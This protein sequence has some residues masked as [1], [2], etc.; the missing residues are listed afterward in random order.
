MSP[1]LLELTQLIVNMGAET[2][3]FQIFDVKDYF[4]NFL[5]D[6]FEDKWHE[7]IIFNIALPS[8]DLEKAY[9]KYSA[10][11]RVNSVPM[12][13]KEISIA[14]Q[15][16]QKIASEAKEFFRFCQ[17]KLRFPFDIINEKF[18]RLKNI[19][20][21]NLV[22][23]PDKETARL[24]FGKD[25]I[26]NLNKNLDDLIDYYIYLEPLLTGNN[27][28]WYKSRYCPV[29]GKFFFYKSEKSQFCSN[30]CRA[31]AAYKKGKAKEGM[32]K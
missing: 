22:Q 8:V 30:N 1:K 10:S 29:C 4:D 31:K 2:K 14:K 5:E 24:V 6:T 27:R 19:L 12:T 9:I 23:S 20:D 16:E 11:N 26:L 15:Y 21:I 17:Q 3:D 25:S 13:S 32:K 18:D 7:K 28:F